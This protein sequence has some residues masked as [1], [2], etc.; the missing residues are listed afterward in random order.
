LSNQTE[1]SNSGLTE[2]EIQIVEKILAGIFEVLNSIITQHSP[3]D[4]AKSLSGPQR[5]SKKPITHTSILYNV[6]TH[7]QNLPAEPRKIRA[8]LP[9]DLKDINS[10]DLWKILNSLARTKFLRSEPNTIRCIRGRPKSRG[11]EDSNRGGKPSSHDKTE[12]LKKVIKILTKPEAK[13]LINTR[14][15]D[16]GLLFK[17]TKYKK[18]VLF[19]Q[20][21]NHDIEA[22][23]DNV[24]PF[25]IKQNINN[26]ADEKEREKKR[27][28]LEVYLQHIKNLNEEDLE[29]EAGQKA[30]EDIIRHAGDEDL[31]INII[32][33]LLGYTTIKD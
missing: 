6:T 22:L 11:F 18:L 9:E 24:K 19:Y 7:K 32:G 16:T 8:N 1:K 26:I 29:H 31:F 12:E 30:E 17:F 5:R 23:W 33:G 2:Q 28:T 15:K 3:E 14:L 20:I 10:T 4:Y 27:K 21:R 13:K 25:R